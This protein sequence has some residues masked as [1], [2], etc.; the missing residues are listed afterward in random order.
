MSQIKIIAIEG[1]DNVGKSTIAKM[2][3]DYLDIEL[4]KFPNEQLESGKRIRKMLNGDD[5]FDPE[6]LQ[7]LQNENKIDTIH[8]LMPGT[9][10][11]DRYKISE[12]VYGLANGVNEQ[13]VRSCAYLLPDPDITFLLTGKSYGYDADIYGN[14]AYQSTITQ[15]YLTEAKNSSGRIEIINNEKPIDDVFEEVVRK[16]RGIDF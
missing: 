1:G 3:S 2:L 10:I 9:Y 15:L 16:L 7:N 14:D 12:I 5:P 13:S 8:A 6:Y 11:F 4:I